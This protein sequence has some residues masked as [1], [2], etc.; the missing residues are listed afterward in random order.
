[1]DFFSR[2]KPIRNKIKKFDS[3]SLVKISIQELHAFKG[4]K[5]NTPLPWVILSIIKLS[6][7]YGEDSSPKR[8]FATRSDFID[9]HDAIWD[10]FSKP[11]FLADGTAGGLNKFVRLVGFQQFWPQKDPYIFPDLARQFFLF[12][13]EERLFSYSESFEELAGIK[14]IEF[15][16]LCQFLWVRFL[17]NDHHYDIST[18]YFESL[19]DDFHKDTINKFLDLLSLTPEQAKLF[20]KKD[21][22]S[23]NI[24]YQFY[25]QSPLVKKPLLKIDD[26]YYPYGNFVTNES[27]RYFLYDF[28]KTNFQEKFPEAFGHSMEK[29]LE[30]G[31]KLQKVKYH[32]ESYLKKIVPGGKSADYA[33][34]YE[35]SFVILESKAIETKKLSQIN[36]TDEILFNEYKTSIIKGIK[37]AYST[38]KALNAKSEPSKKKFYV[39][40]ISYKQLFLGTAKKI[41]DEFAGK[42][43]E[44]FLIEHE[45]DKSIIPPDNIF[46]VSVDEYDQ[47]ISTLL[48]NK[49]YTLS[50]LLAKFTQDNAKPETSCLT[51]SQHLHRVDP[52][53][54]DI[55]YLKDVENKM[56]MSLKKRDRLCNADGVGQL[57]L[58]FIHDSC[59]NEVFCDVAGHV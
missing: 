16:K 30:K 14:L 47:L 25:E 10:L 43:I 11:R 6:F 39:L 48:N 29:Y 53:H 52:S 56:L 19:K 57:N 44:E 26:K 42:D 38:A 1:M 27:I 34:E 49:K 33:L 7:S 37:Q 51:I 9:L 55:P 41:W 3:L 31:I 58:A 46:I 12:T 22:Q 8:K 40:I 35:S 24:E 54:I 32:A 28:L 23:H 5:S 4:P 2:F 21:I 50:E 17:K 15:L 13:N 36:P 18:S 20:F 59:R 45:I